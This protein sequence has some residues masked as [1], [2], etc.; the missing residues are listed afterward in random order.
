MTQHPTQAK[1]TSYTDKVKS[2]GNT[3]YDKKKEKQSANKVDFQTVTKDGGESSQASSALK[4]T[5][6]SQWVIKKY[7]CH[8]SKV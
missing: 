7:G 4:R 2:E 6:Q 1:S 3:A 5:K 8:S